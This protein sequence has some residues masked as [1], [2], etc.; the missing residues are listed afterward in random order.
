MKLIP[1]KTRWSSTLGLP[2]DLEKRGSKHATCVSVSQNS[3]DM[4]IEM[5]PVSTGHLGLTEEA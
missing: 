1:V 2:W 5:V 4:V 3:P